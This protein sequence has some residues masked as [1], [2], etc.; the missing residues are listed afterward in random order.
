MTI[1]V[2]F[3][4]VDVDDRTLAHFESL[5]TANELARVSRFRFAADRRRAT[6]SRGALRERLAARLGGDLDIVDGNGEK[7]RLRSGALEFNVSHSGALIALAIADAAVGIDLEQLRPMGDAS[8][9]VASRYF[10]RDEFS[11]VRQAANRD[12]EFFSIWTAKEAV[13]KAIGTGLNEDLSA[14]TVPS[15]ATTFAVIPGLEPWAVRSIT[16]PRDGYR[17]AL[18]APLTAGGISCSIRSCGRR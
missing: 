14:F 4:S 12:E 17:A 10:S 2:W 5:L 9:Q 13:V 8:G 1:D 3:L 18:A 11:R 7:P 16:P 6:V 15:P